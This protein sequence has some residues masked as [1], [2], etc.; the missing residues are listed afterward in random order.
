MKPPSN[1][2]VMGCMDELVRIIGTRTEDRI[3]WGTN[4][5]NDV[6]MIRRYCGGW[7]EKE[8]GCRFCYDG[9]PV[10]LHKPTGT[11]AYRFVYREPPK[12]FRIEFPEDC[13][14]SWYEIFLQ[15]LK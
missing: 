2:F 4:F 9:E 8:F 13:P 6:F 15:C 7:C 11:K 5:E 10:F 12:M 1:E 3:K 14:V